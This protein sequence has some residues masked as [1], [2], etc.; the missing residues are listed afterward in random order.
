MGVEEYGRWV[1]EFL[2]RFDEPCMVGMERSISE[3]DVEELLH[4]GITRDEIIEALLTGGAV[5]VAMQQ[6]RVVA[7]CPD[8][9]RSGSVMVP[10]LPPDD[11]GLLGIRC[12]R[13]TA[14]KLN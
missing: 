10:T 11:L 1:T 4:D 8:C 14:A 9:G 7:R 5:V 2:F 6:H 13:C 3:I 12:P